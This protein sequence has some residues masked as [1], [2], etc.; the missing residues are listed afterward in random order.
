M[1]SRTS[2]T[3]P[4]T[5]S[6]PREQLLGAL[7]RLQSA[8]TWSPDQSAALLHELDR[9]ATPQRRTVVPTGNRLAEA[10]A[11]AGAALVGAA[12]VVLVGQRWEDLGRPG[13]VALLAGITVV[14]AAV[15]ATV[16]LVRPGGRRVV[17]SPASAVRRR[18]ASTCLTIAAGTAGGTAGVLVPSAPLLA[19]AVTAVV[20]VGA[21]EWLAPS[22]V[23]EVAALG[24]VCLLAVAVLDETVPD[25]GAAGMTAM[26]LVLALVGI[27]WAALSRT[28][29]FT[30]PPLALALG[31]MLA[32]YIGAVGA[33]SGVQPATWVATGILACSP[34]VASRSTSAPPRGRP[35]S[36]ESSLSRSWSSSS[37]AT[38]SARC[39]RSS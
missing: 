35:R 9:G 1:V 29:L 10:A 34:P 2:P 8:G 38:V 23:S 30:V 7:D 15:G 31:L 16:A 11:Y 22:A 27:G 18:L 13:R 6:I 5:P 17:L 20:A 33:F 25:S 36:P 37:A 3:A 14:L 4:P 21:A 12:G 26:V 28:R 39:W 19:A 24:A 32:V